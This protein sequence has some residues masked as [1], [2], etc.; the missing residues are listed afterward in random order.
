MQT[1]PPFRLTEN[2][3]RAVFG[4]IRRVGAHLPAKQMCFDCRRCIETEALK[5][6][7]L[8]APQESQHQGSRKHPPSNLESAQR[9]ANPLGSKRITAVRVPACPIYL[10]PFRIDSCGLR[11][12]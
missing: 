7:N 1:P 8:R 5:Q 2:I 10:S 3:E 11:Y 12:G 9:Y 6:D 4:R